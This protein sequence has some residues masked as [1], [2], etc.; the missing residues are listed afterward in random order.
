MNHIGDDG[1]AMWD[2]TD[3]FFYDVLHTSAG[4]LIPMKV[5]SMVG[6]VPLFAVETLDPEVLS[7]LTG[8]KRRMDWFIAHRKDLTDN[9]AGMDKQG[10]RDRF[11]LSIVDENQLRHILKTVFDENE[12]LSPN[13]IRSVSRF[14]R[15]RPYTLKMDGVEHTVDY[16][17]GESTTPL[18]G[19][20]SNWRGPVWF[21]VN[22][23]LI[24]TLQKYDF[25]YGDRFK[26]EF[27]T[28]SGQFMTLGEAAA[29]LSRRLTR[30]FL[31]DD[32]GRRPVHGGID[33]Y[34]ND[35]N[36]SELVLFYE[37]FNGDDAAGLGASHQTGWTGI[38]AKLI[39]Q[40]GE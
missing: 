35:P 18:F 9:V 30:I 3:G 32:A 25:Y 2:E 17:P 14:H 24:E 15:D 12:F 31:R 26:I 13:G 19:G 5:R 20:N 22:Y 10:M 28:G 21:P 37:F 40:S 16:E 8:F 38:V 11:L 4:Q 23:L 1:A 34:A 7:R 27:P 39:Q 36:W 33:R 29:E 6:L